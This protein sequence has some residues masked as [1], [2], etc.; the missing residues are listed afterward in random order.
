ML[1]VERAAH[2]LELGAGPDW[3]EVR[4]T[5]TPGTELKHALLEGAAVDQF[6]A[7]RIEL[8]QQS[9]I[10]NVLTSWK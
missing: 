9:C 2:E 1:A 10:Q 8:K 3:A 7:R 6:L 5:H 4:R